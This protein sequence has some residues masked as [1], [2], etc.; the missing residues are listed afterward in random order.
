M[1][2]SITITLRKI[3]FFTF[4]I[5]LL[6]LITSNV[7]AQQ[8]DFSGTWIFK[9]QQ[10]ISGNLYANG[11]PKQ[12]LVT[13]DSKGVNIASTTYYGASD[14]TMTEIFK[15]SRPFETK[16]RTGRKKYPPLNG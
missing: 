12:I 9:D 5:F 16:S 3:P 7:F 4:T 13:Q 6:L 1:K 8:T 14:T 10:S 15:S 11:S 2:T